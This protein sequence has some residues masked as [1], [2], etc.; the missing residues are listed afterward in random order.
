MFSFNDNAEY[1]S[2]MNCLYIRFIKF[3]NLLNW[4]YQVRRESAVYNF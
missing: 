4:L 3:D 2:E 1:V